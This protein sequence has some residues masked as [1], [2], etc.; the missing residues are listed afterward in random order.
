VSKQLIPSSI[1]KNHLPFIEAV[2]TS[3]LQQIIGVGLFIAYSGVIVEKVYGSNAP[4]KV[5]HYIPILMNSSAFVGCV[6]ALFYMIY[7]GRRRFVLLLGAFLQT[8]FMFLIWQYYRALRMG[9]DGY[10]ELVLLF[11]FLFRFIA[12]CTLGPITWIYI[13][14]I[15]N[16]NLIAF[17]I[18]MNWIAQGFLLTFFPIVEE[19]TGDMGYSFLICALFGLIGLLINYWLMIET[20]DKSEKQIMI[21]Y[22]AILQSEST[23]TNDNFIEMSEIK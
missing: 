13:P 12:G 17:S 7:V 8:L 11:A 4:Q 15:V 14:E 23:T 5:F 2:T 1:A 3:F 21:E 22:D 16:P 9:V 6:F 19:Y 18:C 10:E 20:K